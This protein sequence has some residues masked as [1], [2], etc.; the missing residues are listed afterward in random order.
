MEA[1]PV[2]LIGQ[3]LAAQGKQKQALAFYTEA[4]TL[5]RAGW[6]GEGGLYAS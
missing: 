6:T 3:T 5:N 1:V 2:K 4:L